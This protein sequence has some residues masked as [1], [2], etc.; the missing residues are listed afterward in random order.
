[1]LL[2]LNIVHH[3]IQASL[4]FLLSQSYLSQCLFLGNDFFILNMME[5]YK[6]LVSPHCTHKVFEIVMECL[7]EIVR[8]SPFLIS[9]TRCLLHQST[10]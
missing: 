5:F 1:M 4:C 9:I 2:A 6:T 3:G 8:F 10:H 7:Q